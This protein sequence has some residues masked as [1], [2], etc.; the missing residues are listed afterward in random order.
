MRQEKEQGQNEAMQSGRVGNPPREGKAGKGSD[1]QFTD[2]FDI[3]RLMQGIS[4]KDADELS[5]TSKEE[6]GLNGDGTVGFTGVEDEGILE[7]INGSLNG[8]PV[9]VEVIPMVG[10]SGDTGIEAEILVGVS[11]DALTIGRI[12]AGINKM[13]EHLGEV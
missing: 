7:D 1:N 11:V 9:P 13:L 10:V 5:D 12:G 4:E 6:I 3:L 8:D 2:G